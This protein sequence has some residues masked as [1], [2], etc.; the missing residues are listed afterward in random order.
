MT[1]WETLLVVVLLIIL[2]ITAFWAF[3]QWI[4]FFAGRQYR[5]PLTIAEE[6]YARGEITKV[7]LAEIKKN[8]SQH[9]TAKP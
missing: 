7:E 1:F 2:F 4:K 8:L 6:R 5:T 9:H 3:A